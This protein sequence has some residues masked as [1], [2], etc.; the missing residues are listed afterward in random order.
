MLLMGKKPLKP[1]GK[2]RRKACVQLV[3]KPPKLDE[4]TRRENRGESRALIN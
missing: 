2:L 1:S 3:K 4:K